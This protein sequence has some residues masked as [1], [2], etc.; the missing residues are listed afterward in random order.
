MEKGVVFVAGVYGVG[1]S[2]LCRLVSN[3]MGIPFYSAGDLISEQNGETY[4]R[5]KA[6]VNAEKNQDILISSVESKVKHCDIIL[7]GH[8]C[9]FD[10]NGCIL[11]I[12]LNQLKRMHIVKMVLLTADISRVYNNLSCRDN[13]C[14]SLDTLGELMQI[15]SEQFFTL[16][17]LKNLPANIIEMSY[18]ENDVVEMKKILRS[19]EK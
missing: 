14:Y 12:D 9:V 6:V 13:V 17:E 3:E 2:H 19:E 11:R 8:M 7:A 1:K 5:N 4:G 10:K 16:A 15:E 18:S